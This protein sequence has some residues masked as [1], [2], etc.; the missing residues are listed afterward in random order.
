[1]QSLGLSCDSHL[2]PKMAMLTLKPAQFRP[3]LKVDLTNSNVSPRE[4]C[5][6]SAKNITSLLAIYRQTYGLRR[7]PL[8]VTHIVVTSA[9]I[10]LLNLPNPRDAKDLALSLT[11][12]REIGANHA[13]AFRGINIVMALSRQWNIHLPSEV[14]Q[15]AYDFVPEIP[16]S[17]PGLLSN[18]TSTS[19][20]LQPQNHV[21]TKDVANG[22]PFSA[23]RN[24]PRP[25]SSTSDMFWSP[26]PDHS[27]PLHANQPGGPMDIAAM[28]DV[29]NNEGDQLN[30]DGFR[31]AEFGPVPGPPV[32]NHV[33]GHWPQI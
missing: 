12:L 29:P 17:L 5:T 31:V 14:A 23:V 22:T 4:I 19:N 10:Q 6:A 16:I 2:C 9:I 21:H 24:S 7:V 30:R 18:M 26:F 3:F 1:M 33:N 8:L 28:L 25:F 20:Q 15:A 11:S 32:Y 27:L 13:F